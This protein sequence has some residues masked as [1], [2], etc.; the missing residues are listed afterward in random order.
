MEGDV[1]VV[2]EDVK[3]G[4]EVNIEEEWAED[5]SLGDT[6]GYGAGGGRVCINPDCGRAVGNVGGE[7]VEGNADG[8]E[9][10]YEDIVVKGVES[11][12]HVEKDEYGAM[13]VVKARE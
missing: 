6:V 8:G 13:V 11:G 9:S 7:P 5:R 2:S 4:E 1:G 12:G 3:H 10:V